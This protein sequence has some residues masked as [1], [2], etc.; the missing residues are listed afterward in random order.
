MESKLHYNLLADLFRYPDEKYIQRAAAC[1][2][3]LSEKFP[4]AYTK[5][6]PF[7]DF[8]LNNELERIEELF[9]MTFHIQAICFLD[10]GYVLFAED[11]KRG[12]FLVRVK[13][14]Q[15]KVGNDCG[16]ELADNLPNVL[17]LLPKIE[18][19]EFALEFATRIM[20]P[21]LEK[22]LNEFDLA[23]IELK[24]KVRLKKTKVLLVV[25][26][27]NR[28]IYQYA[29]EG[30]LHVLLSDFSEN[31]YPD[32][33]IQP[34]LGNFMKNCDS[35]CGITARLREL[36]KNHYENSKNV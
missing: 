27:E 34:T 36:N 35:G 5:A 20:K 11:Y 1:K 31:K 7:F 30:L 33:V 22:M 3:M 32:P 14:E 9:S 2:E 29:L 21:A 12:E 17:T 8:V 10:L 6:T 18:D 15:E 19:K 13:A 26:E 23:R 25:D 28:N 16:N 4:L 24:N